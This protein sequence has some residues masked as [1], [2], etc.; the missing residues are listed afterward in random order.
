MK[1][2]KLSQGKFTLVDDDDFKWLSEWKWYFNKGYAVRNSSY[3]LGKRITLFMHR[4]ILRVPVEM[5]TDH[6]D[7]DELNNRRGNLRIC[8]KSENARNRK[9]LSI[10]ASGYKGVNWRKLEKKWQAHIKVNGIQIHLGYFTT[11]Q[12]AACVYDRAALKYFGEF[13]RPNDPHRRL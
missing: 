9:I 13:A 1:R 6:I 4:E 5:F 2:I 10:N 7:G 11:A 8:T 12:E 3:I